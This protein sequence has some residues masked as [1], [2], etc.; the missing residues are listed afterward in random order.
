MFGTLVTRKNII[1]VQTKN[2]LISLKINM[3]KSVKQRWA[4]NFCT[5]HEKNT[6]ET[7]KIRKQNKK[8]HFCHQSK[9]LIYTTV[10]SFR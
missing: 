5:K 7:W 6:T 9:F 8:E 3:Q 4:I 10:N 1:H 2:F